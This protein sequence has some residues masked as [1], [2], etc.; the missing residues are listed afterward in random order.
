MY[1]DYFVNPQHFHWQSQNAT[2][3]DSTVGQNYIHH[4]ARNIHIHLFVRKFEE[5][6]RAALPFAYLGEIDYVSSHGDKP[7]NITWKL[8][9]PIPEALYTDFIR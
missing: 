1:H 5:M 8:H 9:K 4:Q 7:M 3:H 6:H 2:S